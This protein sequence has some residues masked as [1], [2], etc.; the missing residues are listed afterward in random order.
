[1]NTEFN[2]VYRHY[3]GNTFDM[4]GV[5]A[6]VHWIRRDSTTQLMCFI[7]AMLLLEDMQV[8][9]LSMLQLEDAL[10]KE[11]DKWSVAWRMFIA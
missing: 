8:N 9:Q 6:V 3:I 11:Q 5:F 2:L 1:M 4:R 7:S 10:M